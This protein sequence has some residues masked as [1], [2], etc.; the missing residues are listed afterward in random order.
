MKISRNLTWFLC[1][2]FAFACRCSA[3]DSGI[4]TGIVRR[5]NGE[6]L[7]DVLITLTSSQTPPST[8]ATTTGPSG[9]YRITGLSAGEY[10]VAAALSGYVPPGTI[11]VRVNPGAGPAKADVTLVP[12]RQEAA[13]NSPPPTHPKLEFESSG[14]RGLIDPGG[15]SASSGGAA[16][17]AL[18][19]IAD[20]KRT[21]KSFGE[22]VVTD[23]PCG[24]EPELRE[25]VEKNRESAKANLRLGQFYAVH[26]EPTKA[27]PYLKRA[28]A[29]DPHDGVAVRELAV[30]SL[31]GGDFENAHKLLAPLAAI[32][33]EHE[34]DIEF[35]QLLARADEGLGEFQSA[36]QQYRIAASEE[37]SEESLFGIGYELVLA[38]Q[39]ANG[40]DA[41]VAGVQQYPR[42]IPLLIGLGTVQLLEGRTP[43][44]AHSFLGATEINPADPRPYSFLAGTLDL[45]KDENDQVRSSFKQFLSRR[46]DS[47]SAH[48]FYALV[49]SLDT[50]ASDGSL[51]ESLLEQAIRLD[52][53]LSKAHLLLADTLVQRTDY[54]DAVPEYEAAIRWD[55][56]LNEA[57]YR[58][59]LAY[60][61]I[62]N[63]DL[64]AREMQLF[65]ISKQSKASGAEQI[66]IS[67]FVSVMD[68]QDHHSSHEMQCPAP[69]H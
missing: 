38:G 14:I 47:A 10:I 16:S 24:L 32:L 6:P 4:V 36:A 48:Y 61:H 13:Q 52:P 51:I 26:D 5:G 20:L 11:T 60:K 45:A 44:A 58:L 30:A 65:R 63:A 64:S 53:S 42:S 41:F 49:L 21:E 43:E 9:Q 17:G 7:S 56:D 50:P 40:L 39:L 62:G 27:I 34:A 29:I 19:G 54:E 33:A 57:H 55:H 67:Q 28:L 37:S 18:R 1:I 46:P 69:S 15:Y 22:S 35:H 25:A 23:W 8:Y 2:F 59:A 3:T 12:A 31:E 68:A 66:D